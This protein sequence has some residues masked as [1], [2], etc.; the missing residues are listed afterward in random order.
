MHHTA[1]RRLVVFV[2]TN[3]AGE[4]LCHF[5]D[6]N[7]G[8]IHPMQWSLFGGH[9]EPGETSAQTAVRELEEELGI[10]AGEHDLDLVGTFELPGK[11]Y[12]IVECSR[13]VNWADITL[14]EGAGCG[15]FTH[16]ELARL[17]NVSPLL[18]W[19]RKRNT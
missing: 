5:R 16:D 2:L 1:I 10:R 15:F 12:D 18:E 11:H 19:L 17:E 8:I 6:G 14:G 4:Y 3:D 13:P 9:I 7:P